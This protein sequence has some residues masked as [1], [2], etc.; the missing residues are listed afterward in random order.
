MIDGA[1]DL[2]GIRRRSGA[3]STTPLTAKERRAMTR[4]GDDFHEG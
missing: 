1:I 2:A 4:V 3:Q